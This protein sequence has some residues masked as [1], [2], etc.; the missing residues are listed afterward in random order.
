MLQCPEPCLACAPAVGCPLTK[1]NTE[2]IAHMRMQNISLLAE[3]SREKVEGWSSGGSRRNVCTMQN[4]CKMVF[5]FFI[6]VYSV[7]ELYVYPYPD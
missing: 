3:H 7:D 1:T 6:T 5:F 4:N 2:S